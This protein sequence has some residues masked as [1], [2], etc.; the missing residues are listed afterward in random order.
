MGDGQRIGGIPA[1]SGASPVAR[2][3]RTT[4]FVPTGAQFHM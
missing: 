2:Y 3:P 1:L 4:T